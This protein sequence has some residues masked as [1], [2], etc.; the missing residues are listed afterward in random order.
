MPPIRT[1]IITTILL[2]IFMNIIFAHAQEENP[3]NYLDD[4]IQKANSYFQK[5]EYIKAIPL[6]EEA[7][8]IAE[9]GKA[10]DNQEL[11]ELYFKI[12]FCYGEQKK[13]EKGLSAYREGMKYNPEIKNE[14]PP[15]KS[16][17]AETLHNEGV[18]NRKTNLIKSIKSLK[19]AELIEPTNPAPN[20]EMG[21]A[22]HL[23]TK[24]PKPL[25][26]LK[27]Q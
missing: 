8:E 17:E 20:Y 1:I 4:V 5:D 7:I 23:I 13:W 21:W 9:A 15:Y 2:F 19:N 6:F 16:K 12:G 27:R 10:L 11:A 26:N 25:M 14:S 24:D 18:R 3:D 22:Y